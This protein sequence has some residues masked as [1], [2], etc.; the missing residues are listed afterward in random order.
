MIAALSQNDPA[1]YAQLTGTLGPEEQ[2]IIKAAVENADK[3][4]A[5]Q[6]A[7]QQAN[8]GAGPVQVNGA[9]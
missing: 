6:L 5:Q 4:A 1:L 8:G 9:S 7:E 2:Q 3:I